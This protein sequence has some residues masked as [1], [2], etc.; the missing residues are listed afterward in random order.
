[1]RLDWSVEAYTDAETSRA[2]AAEL[3]IQNSISTIDW[4]RQLKDRV[5]EFA[6]QCSKEGWDGEDAFP[7]SQAAKQTAKLLIPEN[8]EIPDVEPENTGTFSFDWNRG[9]N[10]IL[11]ISVFPGKAVFACILGSEKLH[12][13]VVLQDQMPEK[14]NSLLKKLSPTGQKSLVGASEQQAINLG[15]GNLKIR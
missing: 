1:L 7:I 14:L 3:K 2:M 13:E 15:S 12:G 9:K 10:R 4:R 5:E 8:A 6:E 11:S